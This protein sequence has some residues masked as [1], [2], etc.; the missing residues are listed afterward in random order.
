MSSW[1]RRSFAGIGLTQ[2]PP[3]RYL[4]KLQQ[5]YLGHVL[6][7]IDVS[8]SMAGSPLSQAIA[9]G[10][11][12]LVEAEGAHYES[13]LVLWADSVQRYLP[14]ETPLDEVVSALRKAI[15]RGGTVLSNA[16]RL[17]IDV[18]PSYPGDRVL[19]IFSDGGLADPEQARELARKACA[20]GIRII[21]RGLGP[22]AAAALADLACPGMRDDDQQID[23]VA[24]VASGIASMATGL[25]IRRG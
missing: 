17:G 25:S 23:D 24:Q 19:C 11:Q 1:I 5:R 3:G 18:L 7:C 20:M 13:G 4:P 14:P 21:V 2:S 10:E 9:G 15:P 12:F 8:A 6:L 22:T 16:L